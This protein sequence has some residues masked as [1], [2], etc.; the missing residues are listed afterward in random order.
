MP[1]QLTAT[2]REKIS[3][4]AFSGASNAEI[5]AAIGR[6]CSTVFRELKRNSCSDGYSAMEAQKLAAKRRPEPP[7]TRKMDRPEINQAVRTGLTHYWSPEQIAGRMEH[8][9]LDRNQR[10]SR[11]TIER[12]I[13]AD[14][15]ATH[16]KKFLR[17]RGKRR[18]KDDRRGQ[19]PATVSIA[20]RPAEAEQRSRCGDGEGDTIVGPGKRN[21]L[22]CSTDRKSGLLKLSKTPS[23]QSKYVIDRMRAQMHKL[24]NALRRTMTLDNGKEFAQHKRLGKLVDEGVFFAH[25]SSPWERGTNGNTNGLL[26]QFVPKGTDCSEVS[27]SRIRQIEKRLNDRPRKR[28]GYRTP[29]EVFAEALEQ[30]CC[31]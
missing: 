4:M 2:D 23:L 24:P 19:L 6:S 1:T 21:G 15:H 8:N 7:L 26:R 3:Q 29:N 13:R 20:G 17:R 28:H 5:A 11:S 16:W 14:E 27:H 25:P 12:W 30:C 10:V 18:P 22:V 9:K 31:N